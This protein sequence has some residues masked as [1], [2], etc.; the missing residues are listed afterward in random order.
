VIQAL[1]ARVWAAFERGE[2]RRL[3]MASADV[4]IHYR[5]QE[6][7]ANVARWVAD[8][9]EHFAVHGWLI[10]AQTVFALHSVVD[11]GTELLDITPRLGAD[12]ASLVYFVTEELPLAG[13]P[14]QLLYT[15]LVATVDDSVAELRPA[16][17][18]PLSVYLDNNVWD[19]LFERRLDLAVELP[20]SRFCL[21]ITREAEFEIPAIPDHKA[22]LKAFI[23]NAIA[24]C[25]VRTDSLFGFYDDS[26]PHD[27]QR[28]GGFDV[29]RWASEDELSYLTQQRKPLGR[30]IRPTG[31]YQDEA[32]FALAVRSVHSVVL[33]LDAK[34]GPI[35]TAYR[36]GGKV[37][38]LTEFDVSGLSL[39]EFITKRIG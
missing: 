37:I 28:F 21:A 18:A 23:A 15:G 32:D 2:V 34:N 30:A 33:T 19:F 35:N 1:A 6:C 5:A 16:P 11:T 10:T 4:H 29:G 27:Q 9:P 8:H 31:L 12:A 22:D 38:F 7:H 20:R 14:P 13:L 26:L 24:Q 39:A 17:V 25:G 3:T 36:E